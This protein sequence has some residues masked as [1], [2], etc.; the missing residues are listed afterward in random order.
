MTVMP[1]LISFHWEGRINFGLGLK[2]GS[3]LSGAFDLDQAQ[4][5]R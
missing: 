3:S 4:A 1:A 2:T 5:H